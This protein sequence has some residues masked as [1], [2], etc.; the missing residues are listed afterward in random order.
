MAPHEVTHR[1]V[2]GSDLIIAV[3]IHGKG[4]G[5]GP[6]VSGTTG[7][8]GLCVRRVLWMEGWVGVEELTHAKQLI[9]SSSLDV[10]VSFGIRVCT[11]S[12]WQRVKCRVLSP[13]ERTC[14]CSQKCFG[15]SGCLTKSLFECA[16]G[17]GNL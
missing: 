5:N 10:G 11:K 14:F 9:S 17:P 7:R 15:S 16:R 4:N 6:S 8:G 1:I 13:G 3:V 12:S 2:E